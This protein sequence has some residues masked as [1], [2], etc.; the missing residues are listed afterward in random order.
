VN[1]PYLR[2]QCC[3]CGYQTADADDLFIHLAEMLLPDGD[4]DGSGIAHAE[5]AQTGSGSSLACICGTTASNLPELDAHLLSAFT[6]AGEI[7]P[8]GTRHATFVEEFPVVEDF[9]RDSV[10]KFPQ[11][12]NRTR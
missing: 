1:A 3:E 9:H 11:P 5:L 12:E 8:D 7:G 2:A 6:A 4:A 10:G